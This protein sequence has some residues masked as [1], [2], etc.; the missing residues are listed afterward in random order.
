MAT[1]RRPEPGLQR[2]LCLGQEPSSAFEDIDAMTAKLAAAIAARDSINS[3]VEALNRVRTAL[4]RVSPFQGEPVDLVLWK[5]ADDVVANSW[6]P[7]AVA[8]PE[9]RLLSHSIRHDGYTQPVVSFPLPHEAD[10][11][12]KNEV[13]DGFHRTR[14]GKEDKAVRARVHGYLPVVEILSENADKKDRI[15]ATIRHNRAR[16]RHIVAPMS[17]IVAQLVER[18]WSDARIQAEL[19]MDAEEVLRLKQTTGLAALF[20]DREF[21]KAWEV[22]ESPASDNDAEDE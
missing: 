13:V 7:N 10:Q 22:G 11:R 16:G 2:E 6:N 14:V 1:R 18:G 4:H 20:K 21:S 5:P 12:P 3:R 19:G 15:A 8:P 9:M 17:Q